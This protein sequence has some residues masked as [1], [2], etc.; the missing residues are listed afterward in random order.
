MSKILSVQ[1]VENKS[2]FPEFSSILVKLTLFDLSPDYLRRMTRDYF[3]F[4]KYLNICT[5]L[6]SLLRLHFG[7]LHINIFTGV[8]S[9]FQGLLLLIIYC[10]PKKLEMDGRW[11]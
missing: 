7:C 8:P 4:K 2:I 1:N 10:P 9:S 6:H 3:L 11:K 5:L